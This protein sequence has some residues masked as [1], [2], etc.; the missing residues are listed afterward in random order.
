MATVA[1]ILL[2]PRVTKKVPGMIVA[3]LATT[4]A[5]VL[6][7]SRSARSARKFGG[8]PTGLP[9]VSLPEFRADLILPL[10]PSALTVAMLAAIE[11][12]LSAVVADNM[13]GDRHK[14]D[15]ELVAQGIANLVVPLFGGIPATGAIARTATNI[16][17]RRHV[18]RRRNRPCAR[19]CC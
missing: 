13:S 9:R 17:S 4:L 19:R 1:I 6:Q 2:W 12:L 7:A 3:L 14:P 8:I 16:R 18:A 5:C 10:L 15:V 11:S